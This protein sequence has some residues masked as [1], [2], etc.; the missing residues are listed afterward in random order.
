MTM[1]SKQY[2]TETKPPHKA[3]FNDALTLYRRLLRYTSSFSLLLTA[4]IITTAL[5]SLLDASM[6]WFV[7]PVIDDA[8]IGKQNDFVTWLPLGLIALFTLRSLSGFAGDYCIYRTGRSIVMQLRQELFEQLIRWPQAVFDRFKAGHLIANITYNVEQVSSAATDAL[9]SFLKDGLSV[10]ALLMVMFYISWQLTLI[11]LL[12]APIIAF[13][14]YKTSQRLRKIS[15]VVQNTMADITH[16]TDEAIQ[17]IQTIKLFSGYKEAEQNFVSATEKNRQQELKVVV[18]QSSNSAIMQIILSFP[19]A[20]AFYWISHRHFA[21]SVGGFMAIV[22]AM[23]RM[24]QPLKRL[25]K[26]NADIQRGIAA[27]Q[28]IFAWLD[29]PQESLHDI[30][31]RSIKGKISFKDLTFQYPKRKTKVLNGLTLTIN[32]QE[33]VAIIGASGSG[34][35]S[36]MKLITQ[37]YSAQSGSLTIDDQPINQWPLTTLRNHI[38]CVTQDIYLFHDTIGN[39]IAYGSGLPAD[40]PRIVSAAIIACADV[41]IQAL[42]E[43]YNTLVGHNGTQLSGGQK[44]RIA[45]ARALLKPAP[46]LILDEA[47]SAL[48]I[49]TEKEVYHKLITHRKDQTLLIITHR[50]AA[51]SSVDR[52]IVMKK[53]KIIDEGPP[54]TILEKHTLT[55]SKHKTVTERL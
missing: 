29:Y 20:I 35:S 15:T 30:T 34:K 41:F 36:V 19:L 31:E 3:S 13:L 26:I 43:G 39:N 11:S 46:I 38:A 23:G 37:L 16:M 1:T 17:G 5:A 25:S 24:L 53:G 21:L 54:S 7:K 44:Q 6:A 52:I 18:T 48:D 32:P 22:L 42:P 9:I 51:L 28:P 8:L 33:T 50:L 55:S 12:T 49:P 45:L 10:I 40:D 4:G 47:T 27:A 14:A 2:D